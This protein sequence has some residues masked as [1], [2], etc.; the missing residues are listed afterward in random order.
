[1]QCGIYLRRPLRLPW[2]GM[3]SWTRQLVDAM[4]CRVVVQPEC[5]ATTTTEPFGDDDVQHRVPDRRVSHYSFFEKKK[6]VQLLQARVLGTAD[7][8]GTGPPRKQGMVR[9]GLLQRIRTN[10]KQP[11]RVFL[12]LPDLRA[13]L[14][15]AFPNATVDETDMRGFSLKEQAAWWHKHD[16]V[17]AAHGA[18]LANS[19][20]L[21]NIN[22][23][24]AAAVIEVFPDGFHPYIFGALV[25]SVGVHRFT[26]DANASVAR[27][28][29]SDLRPDP[30]LV[31]R[32]VQ[33]AIGVPSSAPETPT[34]NFPYLHGRW[35]RRR[36]AHLRRIPKRRPASRPTPHC[37]HHRHHHHH[38]HLP[39]ELESRTRKCEPIEAVRCCTISC[40]RTRTASPT[41]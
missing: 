38:H 31:V 6:D 15:A 29:S 36:R 41:N 9:I 3:I 20:F 7:D 10:P 12:N 17:V 34:G 8:A 40:R 1:M 24:T 27:G 28:K 16:V 5:N 26:I 2:E 13:A 25:K 18:A 33:Q 21:R 37:H 14:Q 39:L 19:I 11:S 23:E 30:A 4:G 22:E 35:C 32:L